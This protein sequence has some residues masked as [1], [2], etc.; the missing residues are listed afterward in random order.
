MAA[1]Q[2]ARRGTARHHPLAPSRIFR[3]RRREEG[4]TDH[5]RRHRGRRKRSGG[6]TK[7]RHPL[8]QR[9]PSQIA[10]VRDFISSDP[11][12]PGPS[13]ALRNPLKAPNGRKSKSVLDSRAVSGL[14]VVFCELRIASGKQPDKGISLSGAEVMCSR[15]AKTTKY[16]SLRRR[17]RD[18]W[19]SGK[20]MS[21]TL[22]RSMTMWSDSRAWDFTSTKLMS[23]LIRKI[24]AYITST[25]QAVDISRLVRTQRIVSLRSRSDSSLSHRTTPI[26]IV[27]RWTPRSGLNLSKC[28]F[29][30][31]DL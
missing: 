12:E 29:G 22:R 13:T 15:P 19:R 7:S 14:L 27:R 24:A 9:P 31:I 18:E 28:F 20:K 1:E 21:P 11:T 25:S 30:M 5:D 16:S 23:T 3:I 6:Q 26:S 2:R 4:T 10:A 17:S 8:A